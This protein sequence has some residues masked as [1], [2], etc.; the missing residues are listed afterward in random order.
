M[1]VLGNK[2]MRQ[3]LDDDF[4]LVSMSYSTLLD[5]ANDEIEA[6]QDPRF[7]IA[8]HMEQ[9]RQ[10]AAPVYFEILRVL[11]LNRC[12]VRRSLV[13]LIRE[14]DGL[15]G[16][17]EQLD[18][19]LRHLTLEELT[20]IAIGGNPPARME[21][22]PLSSWACLHKLRLMSW[23]IQLGFELDVYQKDE[24]AGMYW[25]LNYLSKQRFQ[26]LERTKGFVE[27]H[28]RKGPP[29]SPQQLEVDRRV[30]K[31]LSFLSFSLLE[32]AIVWDL[33]DALASVYAVLLR[34]SLLTA[35]PRP[36]STD[37]LRYELRTRP[38]ATVAVPELVPFELFRDGVEQRDV[39]TGDLLAGAAK[40]IAN[41]RKSLESM[42]KLEKRYTFSGMGY[43]GWVEGTKRTLKA[44]I[45]L[46]VTVVTLQKMAAKGEGEV[47]GKAEVPDAEG[48]YHEWWIVPRVIPE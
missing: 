19:L 34:L 7:L 39:S 36:Y 1:I 46:G 23:F 20:P 11:C 24:L 12:R 44:C 6:P 5:R 31:A 22:L 38:F 21:S 35:P 26:V 30:A 41:A 2:S 3:I 18:Q 47:K 8:Q 27:A 43:G 4:S 17:A 28:A 13:H 40:S 42:A 33:S 25:Y 16:D 9:F 29:Q 32:A 37:E 14:W 45:A 48:A 15:H 10:R